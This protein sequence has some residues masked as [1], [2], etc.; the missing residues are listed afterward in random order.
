MAIKDRYKVSIYYGDSLIESI[1]IITNNYKLVK[2]MSLAYFNSDV[3]C[4]KCYIEWRDVV[5]DV[6]KDNSRLN[7]VQQ[8]P[9]SL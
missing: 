2:R 7:S 5:L 3:H 6:F 1:I 9:P 8:I 4:T